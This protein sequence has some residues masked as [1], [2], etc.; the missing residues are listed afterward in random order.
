MFKP[1][2]LKSFS[3]TS[4]R[5]YKILKTFLR[6]NSR[7]ATELRQKKN[8]DVNITECSLPIAK[9]NKGYILLLIL[10]CLRY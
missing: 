7:P 3:A 9:T 2:Y 6:G 1:T 8:Q 5:E 4:T 10:S